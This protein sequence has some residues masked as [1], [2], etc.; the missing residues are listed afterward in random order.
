M[1]STL[2]WR[3]DTNESNPLPDGLKYT[4]SKKLWGTDG[5]CGGEP[6]RIGGSFVPYLEGLRDAGIDGAEE[7]IDIIDRYGSVIVWH[8]F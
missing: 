4:L 8:E 1:S 5:S 6:M 2:V 7:L 3:P